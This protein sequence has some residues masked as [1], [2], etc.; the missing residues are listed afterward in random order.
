MAQQE[1]L[2]G[3]S[4][5]PAWVF[6][7]MPD[8]SDINGHPA[9]R[10][11]TSQTG[12]NTATAAGQNS[13][14]AELKKSNAETGQ[15]VYE[16]GRQKP[17]NPETA[18]RELQEATERLLYTKVLN[19]DDCLFL[20]SRFALGQCMRSRKVLK[21][22]EVVELEETPTFSARKS[23]V[24]ALLK[25]SCMP[26]TQ[27]VK[28]EVMYKGSRKFVMM[29]PGEINNMTDE[30]REEILDFFRNKNGTFAYD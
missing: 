20:L 30:Q 6:L 14:E 18:E 15:K 16:L 3:G 8:G 2:N 10:K 29:K 22:K 4:H 23:A 17:Q 27:K 7:T 1:I 28:M 25:Y 9:D 19:T 24:V 26:E 11:S 12:Q 21:D 5:A 13:T